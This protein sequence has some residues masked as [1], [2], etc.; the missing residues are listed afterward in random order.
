VAGAVLGVLIAVGIGW[1]IYAGGVRL[2]LARFFRV[3]GAFLILVAAGLVVTA[4]RTAHEAGWLNGGQQPT[5]D[6]SWL[7][8]AG[9]VRSALITG[10]LG[11]P[12]D[13]R[14][15]EVLGWFASTPKASTS[16]ACSTPGCCSSATRTTPRISSYCGPSSALPTP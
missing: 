14:L 8:A 16:T 11:V 10:V 5:V 12:A 15:V 2:N 1:G 3:T 4:L 13:P 6:L 9:T 7:V